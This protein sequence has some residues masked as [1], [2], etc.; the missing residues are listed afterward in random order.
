[1]D[2]ATEKQ[3]EAKQ[4]APN[5]DEDKELLWKLW[6]KGTQKPWHWPWTW[7]TEK[8]SEYPCSPNFCSSSLSSSV[9]GAGRFAFACFS[10]ATSK[11]SCSSF[12]RAAGASALAI[13]HK[14][15]NSEHHRMCH[16]TL[17]LK[18]AS[19]QSIQQAFMP[20][21][22]VLAHTSCAPTTI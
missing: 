9:F 4:P 6:S 5:T 7:A 16:P 10:V 2:V 1:M 14:I 20:T 22:N 21:L 18:L 13:C 11:Y 19:S 17:R 3:A 8:A 15:V 12:A